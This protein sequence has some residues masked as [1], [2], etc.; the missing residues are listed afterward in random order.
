MVEV[1]WQTETEINNDNFTVQKSQDGINWQFVSKVDGGGNSS[2]KLSY[3][4]FDTDPFNG[5]SYYRLK[6]VDYDGKSEIFD[7]RAVEITDKAGIAFFPNPA[8]S[9]VFWRAD[10]P[11]NLTVFDMTGRE[12]MQENIIQK[13]TLNVDPLAPGTYLF[14]FITNGGKQSSHRHQIAR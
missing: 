12:V 6:Q 8:S 7:P 5:V 2:E 4:I 13:G 10:E 11:G 3:T 1:E 9:E 14:Q